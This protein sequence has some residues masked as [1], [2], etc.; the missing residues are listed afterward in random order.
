LK[1]TDVTIAVAPEVKISGVQEQLVIKGRH[2]VTAHM[3][4]QFFFTSV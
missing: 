3:S 2:V 4:V 1:R